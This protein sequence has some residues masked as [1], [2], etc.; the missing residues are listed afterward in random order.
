MQCQNYPDSRR[1]LLKLHLLLD[2]L[3]LADTPEHLQSHLQKPQP[4]TVAQQL[5]SQFEVSFLPDLQLYSLSESLASELHD[6]HQV[7]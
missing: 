4:H 5:S 1:V 2:S 3:V 6:D 7:I